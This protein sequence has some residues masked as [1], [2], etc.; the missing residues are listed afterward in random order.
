VRMRKGQARLRLATW[1]FT[2]RR[3]PQGNACCILPP[4][5][6]PRVGDLVLARVDAIGSHS[7]LH[8]VNGRRRHLFVGDEIVVAY[9]NRYASNQF[10]AVVPETLGPCHLVAGGG[11]A[12]RALSWHTHM[13]R[14][15]THITP[16]GLVADSAGQR[17][18]VADY[19]LGPVRVEADYR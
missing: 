6:A 17:L 13:W 7:G 9:G 8:M 5:G 1:A 4:V 12:A 15:P 10:E 16:I 2:T 14:G 18:N 3:I 11:I 19:A